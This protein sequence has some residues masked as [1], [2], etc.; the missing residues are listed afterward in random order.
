MGLKMDQ[1][2]IRVCPCHCAL[3]YLIFY[4]IYHLIP[5]MHLYHHSATSVRRCFINVRFL[6]LHV[7]LVPCVPLPPHKCFTCHMCF[8][9]HMCL[10]CH[11]CF[12]CYKCFKCYTCFMCHMRFLCHM[13]FICHMRF[14]CHMCF[15]CY[16]CF[17][18]HMQHGQGH[19]GQYYRLY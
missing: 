12:L 19:R 3:S 14:L 2:V 10:M 4:V 11:M 16:P 1:C 15:L 13:R 8:M 7:P 18:C 5:S 6:Y 9:F 17:L